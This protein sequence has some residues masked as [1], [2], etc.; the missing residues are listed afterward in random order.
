MPKKGFSAS[1]QESLDFFGHEENVKGALVVTCESQ[2]CH[3]ETQASVRCAGLHAQ[4]LRLRTSHPT[5]W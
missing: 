2:S 1:L 5:G 4:E 3:W